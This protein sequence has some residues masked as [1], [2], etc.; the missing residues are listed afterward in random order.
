MTI[1]DFLG[2][3]PSRL[4]QQ[5]VQLIYAPTTNVVASVLLLAIVVIVV[6][7]LLIAI[8]LLV[9]RPR[10]TS[11]VTTP[12][13]V[14]PD[15]SLEATGPAAAQSNPSARLRGLLFLGGLVVLL[16]MSAG[17]STMQSSLCGEC[18]DDTPHVMLESPAP[19]ASVDCVRCHEPGGWVYSM[20]VALPSRIVHLVEGMGE[21]EGLPE[22]G[23]SDSSACRSCHAADV[24]ETMENT[25]R[26]IRVSHAEPLE[27]GAAC[28]DCHRPNDMGVI[29]GAYGGMNPCLRCHDGSKASNE[30]SLCHTKDVGATSVADRFPL[31]KGAKVLVVEPNTRCYS[32]HDPAPCDSCHGMRIPHPESFAG[33]GHAYEGVKSLWAGNRGSCL[34]CHTEERRSCSGQGCHGPDFPYH[35]AQDP[36]F[37][38]RHTWGIW[39]D[40]SRNPDFPS[41]L[42]CNLCHGQDVCSKCH[43]HRQSRPVP[44]QI[45]NPSWTDPGLGEADE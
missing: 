21:S 5:V 29:S 10:R 34:A 38:A 30:C 9:L 41:A 36:R 8:I 7:A 20:T 6:A 23:Y 17:Y 14:G 1:V 18:H 39:V 22:Y 11:A 27:A 13:T 2:F 25:R 16:W 19:H 42:G 37:P 35:L 26:G 45:L 15:G 33:W 44:P 12:V 4:F 31:E 28:A 3:D 40:G 32:C 43:E 24:E